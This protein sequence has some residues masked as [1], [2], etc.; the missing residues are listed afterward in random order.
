MSDATEISERRGRILA[1]L[2][3]MGATLAR[4]LHGRAV[5]AA[6]TQ[7]AV[8]LSLAFQRI[9]RSTRQTLAVEAR[10]ERDRLRAERQASQAARDEAVER[11]QR[12][13]AQV[14]AALER[15]LDTETETESDQEFLLDE[16]SLRLD[17]EALGDGFETQPVEVL[18]AR[19]RADLA[20][21][22]RVNGIAAPW[23][24]DD[25]SEDP[26]AAGTAADEGPAL[27]DPSRRPPPDPRPQPPDGFARPP[28]P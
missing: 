24:Q 23:A 2:A 28:D 20:R 11:G 26:K 10:V 6:T 7:D 13:K 9:A 27:P 17:E 8:T 16:L 15:V 19:I 12:R 5:N 21:V 14:R 25:P 1:D 18:V 22:A 3:E 4:A